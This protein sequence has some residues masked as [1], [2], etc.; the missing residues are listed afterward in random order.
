MSFS[1][2][3]PVNGEPVT[4]GNGV[5]IAFAAENGAKV[6][7]FYATVL[8]RGRTSDGAPG[9]RPRYDANYYGAFVRDPDGKKLKAVTFSAKC[10]CG[11]RLPR[12]PLE[13]G[14]GQAVAD[15]WLSTSHQDGL[16]NGERRQNAWT[17][18]ERA[19]GRDRREL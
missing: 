18:R 1:S 16:E 19:A 12:G 17:W 10:C 2:E 11:T 6:D 13:P 4:I 8:E 14:Y 9:L 5:H 15:W 7:T 3:V